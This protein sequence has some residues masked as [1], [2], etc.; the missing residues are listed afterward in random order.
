MLR[1]TLVPLLLLGLASGCGDRLQ[2][3]PT[4]SSIATAQAIATAAALEKTRALNQTDAQ[5]YPV[6]T[7]A[8]LS[9]LVVDDVR[10]V[11]VDAGTILVT[12]VGII[13]IGRNVD[14]IWTAA[15]TAALTINI[16]LIGNVTLAARAAAEKQLDPPPNLPNALPKSGPVGRDAPPQSLVDA[17]KRLQAFASASAPEE[18]AKSLLAEPDA[19]AALNPRTPDTVALYRN[20]YDALFA[21]QFELLAEAAAGA[22]ITLADARTLYDKARTLGQPLT[23][24]SWLAYPIKYEMI[25]PVDARVAA[26]PVQITG[27]GKDFDAWA[28]AT[29]RGAADLRSIGRQA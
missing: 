25:E 11:V 17:A 2:P 27:R 12:V 1:C 21:S 20:F 24:T 23:F 6:K 3:T 29:G 9:K 15:T 8:D 18:F 16:P 5:V 4:P 13:L 22:P 14:R 26:E 7:W 19:L 28:G 10:A